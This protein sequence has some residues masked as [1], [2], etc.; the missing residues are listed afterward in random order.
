MKIALASNLCPKPSC[1]HEICNEKIEVNQLSNR[2]TYYNAQM[3]CVPTV[4]ELLLYIILKH[5]IFKAIIFYQHKIILKNI[6]KKQILRNYLI[7]F[8]GCYEKKN[9]VF[10]VKS[11]PC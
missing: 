8:T 9:T 6:F 3:N 11:G 5:E 7:S 4:T 1:V 2:V 10:S